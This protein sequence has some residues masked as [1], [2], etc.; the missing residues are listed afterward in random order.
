MFFF[1]QCNTTNKIF[2]PGNLPAQKVQEKT[3]SQ[4]TCLAVLGS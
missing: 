4:D 1:K 2:A 3:Y